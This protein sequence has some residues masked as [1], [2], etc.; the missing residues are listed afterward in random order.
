ML[1]VLA[2]LGGPPDD[3]EEATPAAA[4]DELEGAVS[5]TPADEETTT[6]EQDPEPEADRTDVML[7]VTAE[8]VGDM[9]EVSGRATVPDGALI[10]Y[11]VRHLEQFDHWEE[12]QFTV[13]DESY[14]GQIDVADFPAGEVEVWVAFQTILGTTVEQPPEVIE[15]YGEMGEHLTG[16]NVE[17]VGELRRVVNTAT[18]LR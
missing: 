10:A 11:E 9:V 12:G 16:P 2:A 14:S 3:D 15:L 8:T 4:P 17:E 7:T 13:T 6:A 18:V 5:P 1:I